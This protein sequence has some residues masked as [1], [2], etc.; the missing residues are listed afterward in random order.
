MDARLIPLNAFIGLVSPPGTSWPNPLHAAGYELVALEL[1]VD[2]DGER[3]VADAVAFNDATN[4]FLVVETK[5]GRNIRDEQARKYGL[6]DARQLVRHTD[7]TVGREDML[8]IEPLYVCLSENVDRILQGLGAA[9]CDYPVLAVDENQ[10]VLCGPAPATQD[11]IEA[12]SQPLRVPGWPPT[13]VRVD[14]ES[15][16]SEF[17][18]ITSQALMAEVN[19]GRSPIS[20]PELAARAIPHLHI[21]GTGYRNNLVKKVEQALER[22]CVACP[23]NFRLRPPTASRNY[24]LVDVV[25]S[26]ER[27]DPRGRT[28]RYQAIRRRFQG[29]D[30]RVPSA[31]QQ[32]A[33]FD[34]LDLG[35][36]LEEPEARGLSAT[37]GE[38]EESE[39]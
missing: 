30:M 26:P 13:I 24:V 11:L 25:D 20:G 7:V 19:L 2:A 10:I 15:D 21:Y 31:T 4:R 37:R 9:G 34:S 16:A 35:T 36:E 5:S 39:P 38:N 12:F 8:A 14:R 32:P 27:A 17:D 22:Q 28:Q 29:Q 23:S 1:P 18:M 6:A 3:V 33:L